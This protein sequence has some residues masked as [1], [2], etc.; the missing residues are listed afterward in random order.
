MPD[1]RKEFEHESI[2][3]RES[4]VRYL[5]ALSDGIQQGY[6]MLSSNGSEFTL[7]PPSLVKFDVQAKHN[8][9]RSQIVLRLSWKNPKRTKQLRVEPLEIPPEPAPE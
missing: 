5:H 2:Q 9:R 1:D 4:L 8:S 6:F 3:D 7:N